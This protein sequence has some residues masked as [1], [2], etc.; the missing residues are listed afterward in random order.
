MLKNYFTA[1]DSVTVKEMDKVFEYQLS[2]G[3]QTDV[4]ET[5]MPEEEEDRLIEENKACSKE[6]VHREKERNK[7]YA[8]AKHT[9][10]NKHNKVL[11]RQAMVSIILGF[12]CP[13]LSERFLLRSPLEFRKSVRKELNVHG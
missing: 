4:A 3:L 6:F 1:T 7:V 2:R 10:S 5:P 9:L 11:C 13:F 8:F 12:E